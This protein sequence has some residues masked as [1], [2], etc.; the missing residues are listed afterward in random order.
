MKVF[1]TDFEVSMRILL[2]LNSLKQPV[3][4]EKILYLDFISVNAKNYGFNTDNLNGD[5]LYMLNELTSQHSLIREAIKSLVRQDFIYVKS[6]EYGFQYSIKPEGKMF[7]GQM[8][9]DYSQQYKYN[10]TIVC[11]EIGDW[12]ISRIKKYAKEKEENE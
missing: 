2:L 6:T 5:G 4:E 8:Q 7:C 3:D 12:N 1:N 9:S 11:E 10:S